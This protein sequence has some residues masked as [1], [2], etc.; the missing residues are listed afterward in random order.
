MTHGAAGR[1]AG[2]AGSP[3]TILGGGRGR[4]CQRARLDRET[5]RDAGD[6]VRA[7]AGAG[8]RARGAAAELR[9]RRN[10]RAR[11]GLGSSG[12]LGWRAVREGGPSGG[13]WPAG[14][15]KRAAL[16]VGSGRREGRKLGLAGEGKSGPGW[17]QVEGWA[18][19]GFGVCW[20][21]F[22]SISIYSLFSISNSNKV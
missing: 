8:V 12:L 15:R 10:G 9:T 13:G 3:A 16:W 2:G 18:A 19:V 7:A 20:V 11:A 6:A 17:A 1:G 14:R 21:F 4:S 5:G 22:F